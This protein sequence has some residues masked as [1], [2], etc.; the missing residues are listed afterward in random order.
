MS[1]AE[2][3]NRSRSRRSNAK[4]RTV[5]TPRYVRL[6]HWL[7]DTPA[8]RSLGPAPRALYIELSKRYNSYNNGDISMSVR[9][10]ADLIHISKNTASNCFRELEAKG[11]I[12]RNQC[13]SFN[14]KLKHATTWIL[15]EFDFQDQLATKDFTR[16]RPQNEKPGPK[17]SPNCPKRGTNMNA[18]KQ[19]MPQC[20]LRLGPWARLCTLARSQIIAR[21]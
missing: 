3:K 8:W 1:S 4:G 12:K 21:I 18:I 15:T 10:A 5:A 14:W 20:V 17:S 7:Q 19:A 11:F 16:W 2:F 6:F 9:E 13:G